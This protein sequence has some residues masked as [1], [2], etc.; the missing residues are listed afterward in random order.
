MVN[1]LPTGHAELGSG[2]K[3]NK[4]LKKVQHDRGLTVLF[5]ATL[6]TTTLSFI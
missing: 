6:P 2:S 5:L 1:L 3:I 4:M